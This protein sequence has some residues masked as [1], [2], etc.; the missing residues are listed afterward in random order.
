[1]SLRSTLSL[2]AAAATLAGGLAVAPSASAAVPVLMGCE[3]QATGIETCLM[4]FYPG[5]AGFGSKATITD[6]EG[7]VDYEVKVT[8]VEFQK[9]NGDRWVLVSSE[10]DFDGWHLDKDVAT[11]R[12]GSACGFAGIKVRA[13][14]TY[15]WRAVDG[16]EHQQDYVTDGTATGMEC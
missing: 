12:A 13:R 2:T 1:M 10:K 3:T 7:G 8:N 14:A 4:F 9:W 11:T 5:G 6:L 15:S 16:V